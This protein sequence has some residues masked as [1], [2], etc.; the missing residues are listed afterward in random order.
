MNENKLALKNTFLN[1]EEENNSENYTLIEIANKKYALKTENVLEIVKIIELEFSDR[2]PDCII[3]MIN[4]EDKPVGVIDLREILSNMLLSEN[5]TD[6]LFIRERMHTKNSYFWAEY[7][8]Y[9]IQK[10]GKIKGNHCEKRQKKWSGQR[11]SNPRQSRWQRGALPLSYAR[12][13]LVN[14]LNVPRNRKKSS[15][16]LKKVQKKSFFPAQ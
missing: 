15:V 6:V 5:R 3:G 7:E 11:G 13:K 16:K 2:L 12:S 8:K 4:Y 1:L 9:Y 14:A 10:A